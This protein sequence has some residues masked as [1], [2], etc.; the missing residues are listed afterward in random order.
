MELRRNAAAARRLPRLLLAGNYKSRGITAVVIDSCFTDSKLWC[1]QKA[2]Q[3]NQW[4]IQRGIS[5]P[6]SA[7]PQSQELLLY[8]LR[9]RSRKIYWQNQFRSLAYKPCDLLAH[10]QEFSCS[11]CLVLFSRYFWCYEVKFWG[12]Y[13]QLQVQHIAVGLLKQRRST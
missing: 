6:G 1:W 12:P 5:C 3:S 4:P 13:P 10:P 8:V 9:S 7:S 11:S 2:I